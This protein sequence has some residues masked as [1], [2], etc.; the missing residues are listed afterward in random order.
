MAL[1]LD[2]RSNDAFAKSAYEAADALDVVALKEAYVN[3]AA[4]KIGDAFA[5]AAKEAAAIGAKTETRKG[6]TAQA[7]T[8]SDEK[9]GTEDKTAAKI[10]KTE[11]KLTEEEKKQKKEREQS[12]TAMKQFGGVIVGAAASAV[13]LGASLA[14]IAKNAGESKKEA[15]AMINAF[16]NGRG[17]E[18]LKQLDTLASNLGESFEETRKKFV[19]FRQGGINTKMSGQLIKL[20]ADL[21]AV[22]GS[23]E[24]ADK[25]ISYITSAADGMFN[26]QAIARMKQVEKAFGGIG[27]GAKAAAFNAASL[28]GAENKIKNV[29]SEKLAAL[30]E[31]IGPDIGKAANRFAD[32][33][34]KAIDSDDGK[35]AIEGIANAFKSV[36]AAVNDE[37]LTTGLNVIKS[38]GMAIGT[39]FEKSG[40][41]IG[42]VASKVAEIFQD[43]GSVVATA[44]SK[45]GYQGV[46]YGKSI[47][48]GMVSGMKAKS[49]E[50]KKASEEM[51]KDVAVPFAE[52]LGIHSPSKVFE[53]YGKDTVEG[54]QR[55]E[56]KAMGSDAMPLQQAAA[57]PV[58][59]VPAVR[60]GEASGKG[61]NSVTIEQLII[62]SNGDPADIERAVRE[63]FQRV[64]QAG[65]LSRGVA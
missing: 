50:V 21:I 43:N 41:A 24:A 48:D 60:R 53:A 30:W 3:K 65:Q 27:S 7:R 9:K 51:A 26:L 19:E 17:P 58:S 49:G 1:E 59:E 63:A 38:I 37:N 11:K 47:A 2:I 52:E 12:V 25:Q 46:G 42:Y 14:L 32:F 62:E 23:A 56:V 45:A 61:G 44:T 22:T 6:D 8:K 31:K 10:L 39:V 35:A 64:L 55:G 20:R 33:L 28:A 34:T 15:S 4:D 36:S 5:K 57:K 40:E 16:T 18:V 13:A 54:F 29:A